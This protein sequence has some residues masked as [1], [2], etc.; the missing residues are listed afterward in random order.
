M[1]ALNG[2]GTSNSGRLHEAKCVKLSYDLYVWLWLERSVCAPHKAD[3]LVNGLESKY[4]YMCRLYEL[5]VEAIYSEYLG[6]SMTVSLELPNVC[7][8]RVQPIAS[9]LTLQK[10]YL[11]DLMR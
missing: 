2:L 6:R 7:S 11:I 9:L 5:S 4:F 10:M 1:H 8:S 3:Q